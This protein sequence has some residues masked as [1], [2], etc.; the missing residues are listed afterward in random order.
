MIVAMMKAIL[1]ALYDCEAAT[2]KCMRAKLMDLQKMVVQAGCPIRLD[3]VN[4]I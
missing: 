4:E 1:N 2:G 3:T